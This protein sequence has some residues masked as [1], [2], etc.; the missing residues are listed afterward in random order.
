[1]INCGC[2]E[3][4]AAVFIFLTRCSTFLPIDLKSNI[5][6][7]YVENNRRTRFLYDSTINH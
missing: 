5:S 4:H 3:N 7:F 6:F 1:M 2:R